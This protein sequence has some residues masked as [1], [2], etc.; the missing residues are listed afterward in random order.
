MDNN[1]K[2]NDEMYTFRYKKPGASNKKEN[3]PRLVVDEVENNYVNMVLTHGD[4]RPDKNGKITNKRY[5]P[6]NQ[7]PNPRDGRKAYLK[8]QLQYDKKG[9]FTKPIK[10]YTLSDEDKEKVENYKNKRI[11]KI[12]EK[13]RNQ[14]K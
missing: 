14:D 5:M 6:L 8:K 2:Q 11:D 7:N 1:N 13:I 3:H 12:K 9:R 4:T 10:N